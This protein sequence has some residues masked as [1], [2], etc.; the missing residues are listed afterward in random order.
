MA[1]GQAK[2]RQR[3]AEGVLRKNADG[4]RSEQF[5]DQLPAV[6]AGYLLCFYTAFCELKL[7]KVRVNTW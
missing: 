7:V 3:A 5:E 6:L 4:R 1:A 2:G